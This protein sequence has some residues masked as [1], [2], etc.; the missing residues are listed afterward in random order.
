MGRYE[1]FFTTEDIEDTEVWDGDGMGL[2]HF[3]RND[4]DEE[5]GFLT[6]R[7][8]NTKAGRKEGTTMVRFRTLTR[9]VAGVVE[10]WGAWSILVRNDAV[11]WRGR[12]L[13]PSQ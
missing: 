8:F 1:C 7:F 10:T 9:F 11:L 12:L 5:C 13:R 4:G 6:R 2:L 3:V